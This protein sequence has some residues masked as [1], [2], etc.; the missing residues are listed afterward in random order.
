M[1]FLAFFMIYP[2][3]LLLAISVLSGANAIAVAISAALLTLS[4]VGT[5]Q[6]RKQPFAWSLLLAMGW[7]L[8]VVAYA[9][10]FGPSINL[11][12]GFMCLWTAGCWFSVRATSRAAQLMQE[13]PGLRIT[14]KIKGEG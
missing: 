7:T 9:V 4:I 13:N 8:V 1:L 12:L 10:V 6:I 11:L 5:I 14:H 2:A 3:G